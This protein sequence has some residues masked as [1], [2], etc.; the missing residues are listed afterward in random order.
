MEWLHV[1]VLAVIQG[2]SEF[3]PVSSSA[4]L[5]L[6][7]QLLGWPD[8][9]LAFDVGVH[10]GTLIA[11]VYYFRRDVQ[12]MLVAF[13]K[14][15]TG[16]KS[17]DG[18]TAWFILAATVPAIGAGLMFHSLIDIY[19]RSLLV[20]A[21]TTMIFGA[22]LWYA[23]N[24]FQMQKKIENL[25]L[26][27]SVYIG[28]AQAVSLIPG[29]SRSGITMTAALMLGYSRE[30]AA[31]FSFF[32]SIPVI[33][34]AGSYK[35]IELATA[36]FAVHW[37]MVLTGVIVSALVAIG[38]IHLFLIWLEK[39]GMLPFVIYRMFLGLVLFAIYFA[40]TS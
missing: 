32:L 25:T 7:S 30:A 23:D 12:I 29:T 26:R 18:C 31:K 1:Y 20:I 38:C 35:G 3:L 4:H 34:A 21:A 13:F 36:D 22:L 33:L 39:V 2:L 15:L 10:L 27:H 5:I 11:V 19:G 8:Q 17:V 40:T 14:S 24:K 6:P 28:M 16:Q 9:G 37:G